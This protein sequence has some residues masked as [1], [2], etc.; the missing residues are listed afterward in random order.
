MHELSTMQSVAT[1]ATG[2]GLGWAIGAAAMKAALA[3]RSQTL[4]RSAL[5]RAH[6]GQVVFALLSRSRNKFH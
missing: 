5:E 1:L 3:A 6:E 2:M 4:L